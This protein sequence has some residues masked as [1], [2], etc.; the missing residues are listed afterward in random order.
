MV[1]KR[2]SRVSIIYADVSKVTTSNR[3][4]ETDVI[5]GGLAAVVDLHAQELHNVAL[6]GF[7]YIN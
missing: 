4:R 7:R 3:M 6:S 2:N 5:V 1:G